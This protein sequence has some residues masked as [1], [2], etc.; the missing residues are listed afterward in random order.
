MTKISLITQAVKTDHKQAISYPMGVR[1]I[2]LSKVIP[3]IY[4]I[5]SLQQEITGQSMIKRHTRIMIY[6]STMILQT[7]ILLILRKALYL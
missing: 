7:A 3:S 4:Q 5:K 2:R 1:P 6:I